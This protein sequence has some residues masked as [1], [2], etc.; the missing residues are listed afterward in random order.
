MLINEVQKAPSKSVKQLV[1]AI[2]ALPRE[3]RLWLLKQVVRDLVPDDLKLGEAGQVPSSA[4]AKELLAYLD[5]LP[6]DE[7]AVIEE[8]AQRDAT[9]G[10]DPTP[11]L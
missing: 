4:Y 9:H 8:L 11:G 6:D 10:S 1:Q 7:R 2:R 5:T 3:E